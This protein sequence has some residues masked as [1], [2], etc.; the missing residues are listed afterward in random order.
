MAPS[1]TYLSHTFSQGI[2]LSVFTVPSLI[3][4]VAIRP[5]NIRYNYNSVQF[6]CIEEIDWD[7]GF[8]KIN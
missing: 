6:R 2:D 5:S 1:S 4:E 7:R 8:T 3:D